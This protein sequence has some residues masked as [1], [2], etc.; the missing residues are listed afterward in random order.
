MTDLELLSAI[1]NISDK[2][3]LCNILKYT[4]NRI[5]TFEGEII[6]ETTEVVKF[7]YGDKPLDIED[8]DIGEIPWL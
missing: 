7:S 1:D 3:R 2:S 4:Q 6:E 5:M 8:F